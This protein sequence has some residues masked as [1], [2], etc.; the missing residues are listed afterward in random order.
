M[1]TRILLFSVVLVFFSIN[2]FAQPGK[3]RQEPKPPCIEERLKMISD[4][5]CKPLELNETQTE[6][7]LAAFK[8]FFVEMDKVMRPGP[9]SKPD[10]ENVGHVQGEGPDSHGGS[11][12]FN[13]TKTEA[14]EKI[15]N[16]KVKKAIPSELYQEYLKLEKTTRPEHPKGEKPPRP[17]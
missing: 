7:V 4:K 15:R 17:E 3:G 10:G 16:E 8:D 2:V 11:G 9:G 6:E 1:R 5:V 12:V 14:L 13:K